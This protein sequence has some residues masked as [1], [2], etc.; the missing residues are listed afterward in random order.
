MLTPDE[1][2]LMDADNICSGMALNI[3]QGSN[4][5]QPVTIQI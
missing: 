1:Y 4:S 2:L 5:I 3:R